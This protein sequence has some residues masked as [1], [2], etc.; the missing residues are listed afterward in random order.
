MALTVLDERKRLLNQDQGQDREHQPAREQEAALAQAQREANRGRTV[1][2]AHQA[3][4]LRKEAG[5]L[6][7]HWAEETAEGEGASG[8]RQDRVEEDDERER[9]GL[10]KS[11]R[12]EGGDGG[13]TDHDYRGMSG[14]F[15][16]DSAI[17]AGNMDGRKGGGSSSGGGGGTSSGGGGGSSFGGGGGQGLGGGAA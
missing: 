11:D 7:S 1:A 2:P 5:R 17:V 16:K 4:T 15:A 13:H 6:L 3:E 9:R 10:H 12:R 8:K 14:D